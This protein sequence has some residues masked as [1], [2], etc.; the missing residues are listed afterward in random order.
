LLTVEH[1]LLGTATG[2]GPFQLSPAEA[3]SLWELIAAAA[4]EQRLSSRKRGLPDESM[5]GFALSAEETLHS[6]QLWASEAAGD[7][8]I[9]RLVQEI[10]G[11]IEKYT[12]RK[13]VLLQVT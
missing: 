10:A 9:A 2:Y 5:L 3:A 13:P 7:A 8:E 4:F 12:G 6:F 1:N 11:L